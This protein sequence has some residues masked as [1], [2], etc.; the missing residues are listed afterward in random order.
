MN[1]S[2]AQGIS[3]VRNFSIIAHINHGKSTIADRLLDYTNTIAKR[4]MQEQILDRM[5]LERERGITIKAKSVRIR[6]RSTLS[7]DQGEDYVLNLIDTPGH[8]DFSYEVSRALVS[9]EGALLI[10]DASQGIEAQTLAN[11]YLAGKNNITLLPVINKIDLPQSNPE[12]MKREIKSILGIQIPPV[13]VSAKTGEGIEELLESIIAYIPQPL[14]K[15][16]DKLSVLIFDSMYDSY[17]GVII[18]VRILSGNLKCN[19]QLLVFSNK[20][21]FY[22]EDIGYMVPELISVPELLEGEVGYIVTGIKNVETVKVGDTLTYAKNAILKPDIQ[23]EKSKPFVYTGFYPPNPSSYEQLKYALDK[24]Y[25]SDPSFTHVPESS[26]ALGF[27]Y[28]CGFLGLLHMEIIQERLLREFDIS[29][30][31]TAPNVIYEIKEKGKEKP[32]KINSPAKFIAYDKIDKI[33]EPIVN[34]TIFLPEEHMGPVMDMVKKDRRGVFIGMKYHSNCIFVNYH[35]PL[36]EVIVDFHDTLKSIT[37]GYAS[38]DYEHYGMQESKLVK[39]EILIHQES[40]DALSFVTHDD[41]AHIMSK[42]I[43]VKLRE[44]I[45]RHLFEVVIQA[46]VKNKIVARET[47]KALKKNVTAK[48]YGGD[49]S[50]KR[51]LLEKQ[52]EGKKKMKQIGRVS[53]PHEAFIS[54]LK[55]KE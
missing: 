44:T 31:I 34:V 40:V 19:N 16:T 48:C 22:P 23:Y 12:K 3:Y 29:V 37:K 5:D 24:L 8:I 51:K 26:I 9:C 30:L 28:R 39:V 13:L 53:I 55:I 6:Y 25:L 50:R 42:A 10:V 36:S 17:K 47:V 18:F 46:K 33:L 2:K 11:A 54:I 45:P 35:I 41:K 21:Q 15:E 49:I 32:Y 7:L 38:F 1:N 4:K 43:L 52:K 20:A 14:H 27:G